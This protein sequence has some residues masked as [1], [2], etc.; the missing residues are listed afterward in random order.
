MAKTSRR[1][2]SALLAMKSVTRDAAVWFAPAATAGAWGVVFATKLGWLGFLWHDGRLVQSTFAQ[3][4]AV[5]TRE[6]LGL[7]AEGARADWLAMDS[8][9]PA[10]PTA[11]AGRAAAR[12]G[13]A[14]LRASARIALDLVDR[15]RRYADDFRDD[16]AD[17]PLATDEHTEFQR[18][19]LEACRSIEAGR[20]LTYGQLATLVGSPGSARAVG[21]VMASNRFAPVVPCHRVVGSGGGLGGYSAPAGLELKRRLLAEEARRGGTAETAAET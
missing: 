19:V 11:C 12:G 20:T 17:I 1:E 5:K 14:A 3:P 10:H 7:T 16:F 15:L 9:S 21:N 2:H 18:R 8:T 6:A 13:E 4:S